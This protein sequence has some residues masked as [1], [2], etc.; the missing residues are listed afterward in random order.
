MFFNTKVIP[1]KYKNISAKDIQ[2]IIDNKS[3]L[4]ILKN[5][6]KK[7]GKP[8]YDFNLP[9]IASCPNYKECYKTCYAVNTIKRYPTAK[10][11]WEDN[12]K[13]VVNDL[14]RFKQLVNKQIKK[15]MIQIVRIHS[16]GDFYNLE[17]L[18]AWLDICNNNS[19]TLF[20]AYTKA[21]NTINHLPKNLNIINSFIDYKGKKYLN[22]GTKD[23]ATKLAE[24][25]GGIVCPITEGQKSTCAECQFCFTSDKVTFIEHK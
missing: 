18:K 11:S 12:Y 25:I 17:Y 20:Y 1:N 6:N 16:S 24:N 19:N 13:L 10:K 22:Y 23:Y 4:G 9:P 2:S 8:I 7:L 15:D 14:S 5:N 3:R 21:F